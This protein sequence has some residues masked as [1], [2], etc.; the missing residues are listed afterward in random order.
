MQQAARI[1]EL[2]GKL[3]TAQQDFVRLKREREL[4]ELVRHGSVLETDKDDPCFRFDAFVQ[5]ETVKDGNW[6][7][8]R[9]RRVAA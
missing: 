1:T 7:R 6:R 5:R 9:P 8:W 3:A 2:E 4:K